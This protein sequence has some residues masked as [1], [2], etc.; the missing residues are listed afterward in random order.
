MVKGMMLS[1]C[2][3]RDVVCALRDKTQEV[4]FNNVYLRKQSM[5]VYLTTDLKVL[6][7]VVISTS[8]WTGH[9]AL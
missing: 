4:S 7:A 8:P 9:D 1:S 2:E 3:L 6:K 5:Y